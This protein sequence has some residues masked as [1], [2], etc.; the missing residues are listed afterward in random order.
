MFFDQNP[1]IVLLLTLFLPAMGAFLLFFVQKD[2][3]NIR[4][5]ALSVALI[6]LLL[7]LSIL[8]GKEILWSGPGLSWSL[9]E[10]GVSPLVP[11]IN[12]VFGLRLD[13]LS[14]AL[15][16]LTNLLTVVAVLASWR[17]KQRIKEYHF[18]L[19]ILITGVLG[20]FMSSD[21]LFFFLF[22]EIELVPMYLLISI[23]GSG[24]KEYSAMKFVLYTLLGSGFMLIGILAVRFAVGTFDI[25]GI[26]AAGAAGTLEPG[27]LSLDVIYLMFLIGF[28]I[29]LPAWPFHT[30]LPDA[31]TDA[32]TPVSI[33]L[34]GI[35]LKMGGY[36]LIRMN[37]AMFPNVSDKWA[38]WLAMLAGFSVIYG[39]ILVFR[40]TDL[41]RVIAYS[42]IS[43]M[44]LVLLGV[45]STNIIGV[46][47]SALQMVAHGT[48]TAL[49][50]LTVGLLYEESGTR[51]IPD[52]G[53][54]MPSIPKIGSMIVFGGLASLGLPFL[55]GFAAEVTVFLGSFSVNPEATAVAMFGIVLTAGYI[56][57]TF[58]RVLFREPK[59]RFNRVTDATK[60][61]TTAMILLAIPIFLVGV[62]PSFILNIINSSIKPIIGG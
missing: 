55:S 3:V 23:W 19:L 34:A 60:I 61:D 2:S 16:S 15:V 30:W 20:V 47:G 18:W 52:L 11:Y 29:K 28:L 42:S 38:P 44:G 21:L 35:L 25:Q 51:H 57:W 50:F 12:A 4:Y 27:F 39:A 32:P 58:E 56:L 7:S 33:L 22:W 24:N 53:G 26:I 1:S 5:I 49:L 17:I 13:G 9:G 10:Y 45:A 6:N 54:L 31:H 48:I 43:H 62:Y 40:Q 14:L 37:L 41:K 59:D 36:G 8:L 46:S